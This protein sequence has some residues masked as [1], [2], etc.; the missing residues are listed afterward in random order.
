MGKP[1]MT[2][3]LRDALWAAV[4]VRTLSAVSARAPDVDQDILGAYET[5]ATPTRQRQDKAINAANKAVRSLEY[6]LRE[7]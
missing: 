1:R 4:Y 3:G 6:R 5:L 7:P 2:K